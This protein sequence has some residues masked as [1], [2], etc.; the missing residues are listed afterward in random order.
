MIGIVEKLV[1]LNHNRFL[2]PF[3]NKLLLLVFNI[4]IPKQVILGKNIQFLHR[5]FGCVINPFTRIGS[6]V[7]ICHNVTIGTATPWNNSKMLSHAKVDSSGG[8]YC[9]DI[10]DDAYLCTGCVILCKSF[11]VVGKGTIV[12]ANAVLTCSTG[13]NEIWAGIP[14]KC[15]G[16][17]N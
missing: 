10:K 3:V 9:I 17:R 7:T 13:E 8:K 11:L 6:N 2:Y 12:A 5:G 1:Y 15:V 14:A 4:E 16:K